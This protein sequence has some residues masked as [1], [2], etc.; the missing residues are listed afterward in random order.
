[1]SKEILLYIPFLE[2]KDQETHNFLLLRYIFTLEY[3]IVHTRA[4]E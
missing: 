1:M 2:Y 4:H 3:H